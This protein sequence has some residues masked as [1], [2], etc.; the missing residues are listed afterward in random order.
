MIEQAQQFLF[1]ELHLTEHEFLVSS[2][3]R[4]TLAAPEGSAYCCR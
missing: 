3:P 4:T 1:V 2:L